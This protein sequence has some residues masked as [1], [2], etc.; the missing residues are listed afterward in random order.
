MKKYKLGELFCGPGGFAQG[1]ENTDKFKHVWAIDKD[2]DT[3]KTFQLNHPNCKSI[4]MDAKN[5]RKDFVQSLDDINGLI[6]GFPCNDF[7]MA[8]EKKG[9]NGEFGAL[10]KK[11]SFVLNNLKKKP[12]FFVAENV[13][14]IATPNA[15]NKNQSKETYKNFKKIMVDLASCGYSIYADTFNFA[16]YSVPQSRKRI[17]LFGIRKDL[18]NKKNYVKPDPTTLKAITCKEALDK[19]YKKNKKNILKN[20]EPTQ[21][22]KHI[23][24]RLKKT[25]PGQNVWDIGEL[26]NVKSARMS[27][28]YKKLDPNKPAYTVTGSGGGGTYMYHYDEDRALTNRER[29]TLQTFPFDYMFEGGKG[30]VRKQIGMAVPVKAAEI[31]MNNIYKTLKS[32][33]RGSSVHDW[34]IEANTEGLLYKKNHNQEELI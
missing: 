25:K 34:F 27:N 32:K 21:H 20:N 10:Y 6:F 5:L 13:S 1:A 4:I 17:I 18:F 23:I 28:I 12:E 26:P 31:I 7:S 11:A 24:S 8:G 2:P 30:S 29:A 22:Q 14:N 3:I 33:K 9:F 19:M 16:E 15:S